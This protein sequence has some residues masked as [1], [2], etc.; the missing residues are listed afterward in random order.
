MC[1]TQ[2]VLGQ[3]MYWDRDAHAS[4]HRTE[5]QHRTPCPQPHRTLLPVICS[6]DS[7]IIKLSRT[8]LFL[9]ERPRAASFLLCP[10]ISVSHCQPYQTRLQPLSKGCT[11]QTSSVSECQ[12]TAARHFTMTSE[13]P[14]SRPD[15]DE[16][17][18][19]SK[20]IW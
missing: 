17:L 7:R 18:R 12:H 19:T 20:T 15:L 13:R 5:E 10:F 14:S 11:L 1:H 2:P 4:L 9:L 3:V 16:S 6:R 8:H